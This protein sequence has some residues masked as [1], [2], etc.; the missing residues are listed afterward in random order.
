[1][2]KR[3]LGLLSRNGNQFIEGGKNILRKSKGGKRDEEKFNFTIG[4]SI[5]Y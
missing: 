2:R 5:C 1:M 3:D 4:F